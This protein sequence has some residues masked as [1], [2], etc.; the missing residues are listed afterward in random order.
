MSTL[1]YKDYYISILHLPDKSGRSSSIACV[2][3][4]HELD[5]VPTVRW[6]LDAASNNAGTHAQ[7]AAVAKQWIDRQSAHKDVAVAERGVASAPLRFW[8]KACFTSLA[9]RLSPAHP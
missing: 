6:M 7:R 9:R 1:R 8:L 5:S 4:R 2:E 3:V